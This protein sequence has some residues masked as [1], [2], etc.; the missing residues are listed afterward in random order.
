M[1]ELLPATIV[2]CFLNFRITFCVSFFV[3]N[4]KSLFILDVQ[5]Y[6]RP[7]ASF[8]IIVFVFVFVENSYFSVVLNKIYNI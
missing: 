6:C 3:P 2:Q 8:V 4:N 7:F 5:H 1:L